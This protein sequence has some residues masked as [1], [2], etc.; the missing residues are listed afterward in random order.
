MTKKRK[1]RGRRKGSKGR[2]RLVQCASCGQL[3]PVDKAKKVYKW[4]SLIEGS[5]SKE[6]RQQGA[7]LPRRQIIKYYCVSCAIHRHVVSPR[8]KEDRRKGRN[9]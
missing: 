8:S 6:L 1:N 9:K 2:G 7:Y 4:V 3:I 5:L